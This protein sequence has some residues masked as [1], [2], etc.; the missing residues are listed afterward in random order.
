MVLLRALRAVPGKP[1]ARCS[2]PCLQVS[3]KL[4]RGTHIVAFLAVEEQ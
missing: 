1:A 3:W 2:G 4:T